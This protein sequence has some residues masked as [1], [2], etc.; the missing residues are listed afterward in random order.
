[1]NSVLDPEQDIHE[2][3]LLSRNFF[4]IVPGIEHPLSVPSI[5]AGELTEQVF[6][7]EWVSKNRPILI[8]GAV[9][10]WPAVKKWRD[11]NFWLSAFDN[12]KVDVFTHQNYNTP[13]RQAAGKE[14]MMF[15]DAMERLFQGRDHIFSMPA[16][17]ITTKNQ[18][19]QLIE[20]T[21]GFPFLPS[22]EKPRVIP[23]RRLFIYRRAATAW[24]YHDIDETLMCQVKGS[25]RTAIFPPGV[26]QIEYLSKFFAEELHLKGEVLD[27]SLDLKPAIVDVNEGDALYIPPYWHHGVVPNDGDLGFTLAYCWPSPLHILGDFKNYFV[28]DLYKRKIWPSGKSR[29]FLPLIEAYAGLSYRMKKG[30][31]AA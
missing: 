28:R 23:Q 21:P 10:H 12:F 14:E 9:K 8:K 26:P 22:P 11:K 15:H 30:K 24:H 27:K 2:M 1:M 5:D 29:M 3:R 17:K 7:K 25:K 4:S 13:E 19:A 31:G 6:K 18:F 20:D 16:K